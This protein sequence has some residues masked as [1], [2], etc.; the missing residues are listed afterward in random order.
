[1]QAWNLKEAKEHFPELLRFSHQEPQLIYEQG[2][3][4]SVLLDYQ[5]FQ[6]L[7]NKQS[8]RSLPSMNELLSEI[9]IISQEEG[10]LDI[11]PRQDRSNSIIEN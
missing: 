2:Q 11:L 8:S 5:F 1:M 3:L 4:P 10:E 6:Q 7:L 9:R